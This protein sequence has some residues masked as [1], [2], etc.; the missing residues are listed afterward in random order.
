[1]PKVETFYCT[2]CDTE[3]TQKEL[4]KHFRCP[5]C[6]HFVASGDGIDWL[7]RKMNKNTVYQ[8]PKPENNEN[9]H[10]LFQLAKD[11]ALIEI[12][13]SVKNIEAQLQL[14]LLKPK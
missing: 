8:K 4:L 1:M 6:K 13:N 3:F 12:L 14:L 2:I 5:H 10:V 9:F 11:L 7:L